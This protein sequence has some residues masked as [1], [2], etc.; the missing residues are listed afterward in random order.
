NWDYYGPREKMRLR[1]YQGVPR[2]VRGQVWALLL[3]IEKVKSTQQGLY[4]KMKEQAKLSSKDIWQI[5]LDVNWTFRNQVMLGDRYGIMQ[6]AL[7]HVLLAYSVYNPEVGICQGMT[8]IVGILLMYLGE[9]DTFWAP[10][11]L[12]TLETHA[13]H[14]RGPAG[15]P[16]CLPTGKGHGL[17]KA[18]VAMAIG[19]SVCRPLSHSQ[20]TLRWLL[21][22]AL[23]L[24]TPFTLNL[25]LWDAYMLD[26]E[27]VLTAMAYTVLRL[28]R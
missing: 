12:M 23:S 26:G 5:D 14:G 20:A 1:V 4:E 6:R 17:L 13:M 22:H 3:Y 11:Q 16:A 18:S 10:A 21:P 9:E 19:H 7:F 27:R 2:Q 28:H 25:K 24:Q 8:D 15:H